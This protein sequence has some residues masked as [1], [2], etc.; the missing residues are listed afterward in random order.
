[1]LEMLVFFHMTSCNVTWQVHSHSAFRCEVEREDAKC[2]IKVHCH[3]GRSRLR[4]NGTAIIQFTEEAA[5]KCNVLRPGQI[6]TAELRV[7]SETWAV[8]SCKKG[9]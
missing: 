6:K 3:A 8:L 9:R 1:M 4:D 7:E 2:E 5:L